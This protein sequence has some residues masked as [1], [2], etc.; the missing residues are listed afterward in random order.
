MNGNVYYD[1]NY[2][3][4]TWRVQNLLTWSVPEIFPNGIKGAHFKELGQDRVFV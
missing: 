3:S 4:D 1:G 2:P